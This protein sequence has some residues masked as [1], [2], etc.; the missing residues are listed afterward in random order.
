MASTGAIRIFSCVIT[1]YNFY[2]TERFYSG[3]AGREIEADIFMGVVYYQRL[4][5]MV[6]D[7]FQASGCL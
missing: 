3:V 7:K 6:S 4:R 5:H 1:G 2:G